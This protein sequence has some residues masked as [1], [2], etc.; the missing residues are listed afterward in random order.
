MG[1]FACFGLRATRSR[2]SSGPAVLGRFVM[3]GLFRKAGGPSRR[4]DGPAS[5]GGGGVR[6]WARIRVERLELGLYQVV[7]VCCEMPGVFCPLRSR[8]H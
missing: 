3:R 6:D 1:G 5:A 7:G 8:A 2:R 4:V